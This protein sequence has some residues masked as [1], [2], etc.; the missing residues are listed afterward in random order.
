MSTIWTQELP[1]F[2]TSSLVRDPLE[3][4]VK[5]LFV[6][7]CDPLGDLRVFSPS[8]VG[9][10]V[11]ESEERVSMAR[12]SLHQEIVIGIIVLFFLTFFDPIVAESLRWD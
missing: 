9:F 1:F 5:I 8:V 3:I 10:V 4:V 7:D 6:L 11:A 2:T 12:L